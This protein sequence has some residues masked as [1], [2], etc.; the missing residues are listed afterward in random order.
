[1]IFGPKMMLKFMLILVMNLMVGIV[2][3][4][5]KIILCIILL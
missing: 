2:A 3:G 4:L 5:T 1:M